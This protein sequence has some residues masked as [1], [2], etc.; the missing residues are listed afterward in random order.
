MEKRFDPTDGVLYS[1]EEMKT[2]Y[3]HEYSKSEINAWWEN[4]KPAAKAKAKMKPKA[5]KQAKE[6]NI[7]DA[8][9]RKPADPS[10]VLTRLEACKI[11]PVIKLDDADHA[12][13][14]ASALLEGG[15]DI[16]EIT[17]RTACAA[18]A[19]K[20]ASAV[21]GVCVGA[22]TVLEPKQVDLAVDNGADF[23]ISPGFSPAVA[24]RCRK[25]GVLYIPAVITPTEVMAVMSKWGLKTLK[26]FPASN[27]GGAGT[28][29]SYGAVFP[30]IKFMP[31]GGV[32][33][34]NIGD[35]LGLPNVIAAGG[36]WF[37]SD[38]AIKKAAESG[39]WSDVAEGAKKAKAVADASRK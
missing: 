26:F 23:I 16:N 37:V 4:C 33:E 29:K 39:S 20:K 30:D 14:L 2:F 25:R 21:D 31:T 7:D 36:T 6:N 12:A 19:I 38:A 13:P 35:F 10:E 11:V 28:L 34:A 32:T 18:E 27:F 24:T 1:F 15:I 5:K 9:K 22:G 17:F 8:P 3:K